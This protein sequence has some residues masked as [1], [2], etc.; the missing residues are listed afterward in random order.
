MS[1]SAMA[2]DHLGQ[3]KAIAVHYNANVEMPL[4]KI[5][6]DQLEAVYGDQLDALI[7]SKQQ[8][9]KD[10]KNILRNRVVIKQIT[11]QRDQKPC[12]MLSEVKL[13]DYYVGGLKRDMAFNPRSFNPLK[14]DFNFYSRQSFMYRVD[15][16][17]YFIL[18]KSQ[19]DN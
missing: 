11:N 15:G 14:Y 3:N 9:L 8:R 6:Y 4:N 5:E 17:D 18:I 12:P 2:Q 10:V 19:F 13:F 16:T 1:I 7:L